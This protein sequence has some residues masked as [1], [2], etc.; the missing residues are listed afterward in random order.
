MTFEE[1]KALVPSSA[2]TE[3]AF[4]L[5]L[6]QGEAALSGLMVY[7][8]GELTEEGFAEYES[9]LAVQIEHMAAGGAV[10]SDVTSQ[11]ALGN[12]TTFAVKDPG[13]VNISPFARSII[14]SAGLH[15]RGCACC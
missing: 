9:A 5:L 3:T 12:S 11:S 8:P 4:P 13:G 2:V 1:F 7:R 14:V 6:R 15:L 10:N